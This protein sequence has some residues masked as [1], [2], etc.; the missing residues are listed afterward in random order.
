MEIIC[1][2]YVRNIPC[3]TVKQ[4]ATKLLQFSLDFTLHISIFY[5][6]PSFLDTVGILLHTEIVAT[7]LLGSD[8]V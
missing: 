6:M 5:S 1:T 2:L 7:V 3:S 4:Q 8:A